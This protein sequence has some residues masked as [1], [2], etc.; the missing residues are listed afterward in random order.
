MMSSRWMVI[1]PIAIPGMFLVGDLAADY[2]VTGTFLF[3]DRLEDRGGFTGE[4][5]NSPIRLAD[6]EVIDDQTS[7]VLA[8]GAT[9]STGD[10]S[11]F[12]VDDQVRDVVVRVMTTSENV[13]TL[14]LKVGDWFG[15]GTPYALESDAVTGHDPATDID[16]GQVIAT[17]EAAGPPFNFYDAMF[18]VLLFVN[19]F[20]GGDPGSYPLLEGRWTDNANQ[21]TAFYNG[22]V[23]IGDDMIY[24]DTVIQ[25]E[26]GHWTNARFSND[27]NPG[28]THYINL[29]E[30][31]PRLAYGEGIAS[32]YSDATRDYLGLTPLPHLHVVTTGQPGAGNLNFAYEVEGPSY[33]C[34]GPEHEITT[35][36]V[37][38]DMVDGAGTAD[39][40]P[41]VDDDPMSAGYADMW[42]VILHYIPYQ[43]YPITL[44]DFWDG[45][46]ALGHGMYDEMV[47]VWGY[48]EMEYFQDDLEP[49]DNVAL[50]SRL[51]PAEGSQHHTFYPDND[52][53]WTELAIVENATFQVRGTNIVPETYPEITVYESDG[54]TE[55]A[56]N[57]DNVLMP[58]EFTPT[59]PGPYYAMSQQQASAFTD[60][61]GF[62]LEF[63]VSQAPPE[64]AQ[65]DVTPGIFSKTAPI[66]EVLT[67]SLV[68]SNIGGGP[69][70]Y[71]ISDRIRFGS[72][73]ADL[74][75][76]V[77]DPDS[78]L[79]APGDSA[80]VTVTFHS[81]DLTPDSTYDALIVVSSNDMVDPDVDIIVRLT[82]QSP[83][84]I[85]GGIASQP[86]PKVFALG[87]N[88][89]NPFN[90]S[91]SIRYDVPAEYEAGVR[92]TLEVF[93][94]RG[95]R[96]A[97]LVDGVKEA[98]SYQVHWDGRD[99]SGRP[100]GSG[101]YLYRLEA[102]PF[103]ATRKMVVTR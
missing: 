94:A 19:A 73:P 80:V 66:G 7:E 20:E 37:L 35:N 24:D 70:R 91:T 97:T 34:P 16:M 102:G 17:W 41:G 90:P 54:V 8:A 18:D 58:I 92:V 77:E 84:G 79:V 56:S 76:L 13:P 31:D 9:D 85:G 86:L 68:V 81:G 64:S 72:D 40:T 98:G 46:F 51:T 28:G 95:Q 82:T 23:H 69:L 67:D 48:W 43:P 55:V 14:N 2:T 101:V 3:E 49:D 39:D 38:W 45:W 44:E 25:H 52:Q 65:I 103:T 27:S 87:Q 32:W 12:V 6:V 63:S 29:C 4:I 89:P 78:G 99:G 1:L 50:A 15:G 100:V 59:G 30:Q 21:G 60:Y 33:Y 5:V 88:R 53:D 96:V 22:R 47:E 74:T 26:S 93:N 83:T 11:I 62:D 75:W 36:A 57:R 10:F 71:S 61:G 42:D